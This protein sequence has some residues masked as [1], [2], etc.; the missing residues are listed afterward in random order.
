MPA[1]LNSP[2]MLLIVAGCVLPLLPMPPLPTLR[3]VFL[4]EQLQGRQQ[5]DNLLLADLAGP[6]DAVVRRPRQLVL[7]D[8]R[9]WRVPL[10]PVDIQI[11]VLKGRGG[12]EISP[13]AQNPRTLRP[14][15]R[16]AAAEDHEVGA[17]GYEAPKI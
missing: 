4:G 8:Q 2:A 16:L 10:L 14:P 11:Q 7:V 5:T 9:C 1:W 3:R 6:A 12:D 13:A 15:Q 17:V